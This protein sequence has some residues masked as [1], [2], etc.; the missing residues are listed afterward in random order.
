M[1]IVTHL[2]QLTIQ[3]ELHELVE[4]YLR[5]M[6]NL[7]TLGLLLRIFSHRAPV[8]ELGRPIAVT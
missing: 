7:I 4:T 6:L 3:V 2:A 8:G 1:C 5:S